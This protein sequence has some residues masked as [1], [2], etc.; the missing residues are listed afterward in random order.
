[1]KIVAISGSPR[2]GGNTETAL[3]EAMAAAG[4]AEPEGALIRLND[5]SFRGCQGCYGCRVPG[6]EGCVLAD[7]LRELYQ[8]VAAAEVV[9]LG[10]PVY[11]GYVTGQMKSCLDRFYAFK[12]HRREP[13]L[14]PGK[15]ALFFLVQGAHGEDHYLWTA[16]SLERV[17]TSYGFDT[18]MMVL[19]GCEEM[20]ALR[21]RPA[22]L[23]RVREAGRQAAE[24]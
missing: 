9:L 12:D 14:V 2:H 23:E 10:S 24:V 21:H 16:G 8:R 20:G 15:R 7:D 3:L 5:L 1:M 17:L 13:R 22:L 6:S 4:V 11:Y 18:R 19:P